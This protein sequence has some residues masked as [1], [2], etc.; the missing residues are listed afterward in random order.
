MYTLYARPGWGSVLTE[1]QLAWYGLPYRIE[2]VGDLF[3]DS[4]A[5][6]R[7]RGVNPLSQLPTL[8]LPDGQVMTESAAIT[9]HL[10]EVTGRA[11]LVPAVP[12]PRFLRW[13]V[14]LVANL[15]PTFTYA[16]EPARFVPGE[17]AQKAFRATVDAYAKRLWAIVEAEAGTPWFLG[18]R[19]SA[20]DIFIASMT[21]WRPGRE[22]FAAEAPKLHAIA[23]AAEASPQIAEV[24]RRNFPPAL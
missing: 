24:W 14:F 17:D 11:D 3:A 5:A 19:F 6:E 8:V 2:E 13:L 7:L 20:L 22:W 9:L 21:R 10:A 1:V 23:V 16:D 18:D 15:Y 4:E 12:R